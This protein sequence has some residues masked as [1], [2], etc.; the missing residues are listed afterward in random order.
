M[1]GLENGPSSPLALTRNEPGPG[2]QILI[3]TDISSLHQ[4]RVAANT[5]AIGVSLLETF[6]PA[7][8][9]NSDRNDVGLGD[10]ISIAFA[11]PTTDPTRCQMLRPWSQDG[12][13][14][15]TTVNA[16]TNSLPATALS[17]AAGPTEPDFLA[18]CIGLFEPGPAAK[19]ILFIGDGVDDLDG[20]AH[21]VTALLDKAQ[22][23]GISIHPILIRS[24][25]NPANRA[26]L[27]SM[28]TVPGS[29]IPAMD[30]TAGMRRFWVSTLADIQRVWTS[31]IDLNS[32]PAGVSF[33]IEAIFADGPPLVKEAQT[34]SADAPPLPQISFPDGETRY[35]LGEDAPLS[36]RFLLDYAST[37]T[38][39]PVLFS[40]RRESTTDCRRDRSRTGSVRVFGHGTD[41]QSAVRRSAPGGPCRG[42]SRA[43][44]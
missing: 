34:P 21:D 8:G 35:T 17:A 13:E 14:L 5:A 40:G 6:L 41:R 25:A 32:V 12:V 15:M 10:D 3:T 31:A 43:G 11:G 30:D 37:G 16:L 7:I 19:L 4:D 2:V 39:R 26:N 18:D 9:W 33:T 27:Q 36:V 28:A 38:A 23:N 24:N 20:V 44:H 1:T 42:P 22:R 29:E